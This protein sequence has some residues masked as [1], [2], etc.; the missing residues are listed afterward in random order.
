MLTRIITGIVLIAA[1]LAWLFMA[2]YPIFTLGALFIY[3]VGAYEMGP[4]LGYKS[5]IPFTFVAMLAASVLFYIAPPGLYIEATIP[6]VVKYIIASGVVVWITSL[7]LLVKFPH[8]TAWHQYKILNTVL[9]ILM[10]LPFLAGLL[11]LRSHNYQSDMLSGAYLVLA[12]MALVWCADSGAYFTG[13]FLGKTPMLPRVS[14][15]KTMEGLAGGLLTAFI[16]MIIFYRIGCFGNYGDNLVALLIAAPVAIVFSVIGDLVESMFK[17]LVNIKDSGKIFPGHGGMLDRI[18]S[19]L[20]AIPMFLTV[21]ML[22][23]GDLF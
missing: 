14:P 7:P 5:K 16:A 8:D 23:S 13:R 2:S 3:M 1:V 11:V 6:A 21:S 10:L 22:I 12:V 9:G 20:A 19:Q 4:L 15:K 18:D 17:R